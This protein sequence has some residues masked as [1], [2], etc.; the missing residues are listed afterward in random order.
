MSGPKGGGIVPR[1]PGAARALRS[2]HAIALWVWSM[3]GGADEAQAVKGDK[4]S[5]AGKR[6]ED[7]AV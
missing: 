6:G 4:Q 2:D 3:E 7:T 5:V 1:R